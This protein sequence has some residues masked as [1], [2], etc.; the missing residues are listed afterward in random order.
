MINTT[1]CSRRYINLVVIKSKKKK[2]KKKR[3]P[4]SLTAKLFKCKLEMRWPC[5]WNHFLKRYSNF[6][7]RQNG[8]GSVWG[9]PLKTAD[10]AGYAVPKSQLSTVPEALHEGN[11]EWHGT[12]WGNDID[13]PPHLLFLPS[14]PWFRQLPSK[15]S[16][17]FGTSSFKCSIST[18]SIQILNVSQ[19]DRS[20]LRW[21]RDHEGSWL[22][23][24]QTQWRW[25][26]DVS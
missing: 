6:D 3:S 4:T 13:E 10:P 18:W 9:W 24:S 26:W 15:L 11:Q 17:S 7:R 12:D 21:R 19:C 23:S 14:P 25:S 8:R 2:K 20:H 16:I 5:K 1:A 22:S